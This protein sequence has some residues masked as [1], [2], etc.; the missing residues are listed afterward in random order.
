M[1]GNGRRGREDAKGVV[2]FWVVGFAPVL[3]PSASGDETAGREMVI[4]AA[5]WC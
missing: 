3:L 4:V 5:I 2:R 1:E